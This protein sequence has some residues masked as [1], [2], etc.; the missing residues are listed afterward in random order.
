[1]LDRELLESFGLQ[2][3]GAVVVGAASGLGRSTAV[4]FARAGARIMLL[5]RDKAG[6]DQTAEMIG[7]LGGESETAQ[8]DVRDREQLVDCAERAGDVFGL[9]IWANMAGV[10]GQSTVALADPAEY[11]RIIATNMHGTY[12]GCAAAAMVMERQGAGSIINISSASADVPIAGLSAYAMSK[13]AV[14]MLTRVLAQELGPAGIRVN[15]VA[16]GYVDTPM[17]A[18]RFRTEN[19]E[20]DEALRSRILDERAQ[21]TALRRNGRPEDIALTMLFLASDAS[22]FYTGQ[23]LRPN[24][25]VAM[26]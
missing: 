18:F 24:G 16:P 14:G 10:I 12:W 22:S 26:P 20:I 17:I 19:G 2:G 21:S 11:E 7:A 3:K 23:I 25:G 9:H 5:D 15:A 13:A 4:H 6:L 1:M 8:V